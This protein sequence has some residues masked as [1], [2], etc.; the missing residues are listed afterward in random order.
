MLG[1][2]VALA[3]VG[4]LGASGATAAPSPP[5]TPTSD[6]YLARLVAAARHGLEQ[7]VA[8]RAPKLVPPVPVKVTWK[9]VRLGALDLGGPLIALA[10]SDLDGDGKAEL[11]AVTAREVIA[12][13]IANHRATELARVPFGGALAAPASRDP[14]GTATI[15]AGQLIA[16]SS[17]WDTELRVGW[18]GGKLVA[19]PG[20]AV[21]GQGAL[22]CPG[23]RVPRV[24]GR[25]HFGE[26]A[27]PIYAVRCRADLVDSTGAPLRVHGAL[28]GTRLEVTIA[29]CT[30]AAGG[31]ATCEAAGKFEYKDYGAAFELADVDHDGRPELIVTGSGAPGDQDAVKVVTLGGDDK[32][33]LFRRTFN[34]GVAAISVADGDGDGVAEVIAAVRLVGATRVDLWRL[35]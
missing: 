4:M 26:L 29:R 18:Q 17:A 28:T 12:I 25:N 24:P 10:A 11:Y 34:G 15:E 32:K 35:D 13:G 1:R 2:I 21:G 7:V 23:E 31:G 20:A 8:S 6:D 30:V 9:A 16:S 5:P 22:V 33:G 27:Q 14:V 19:H 3:A